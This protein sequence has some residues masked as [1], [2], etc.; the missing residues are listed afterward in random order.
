MKAKAIIENA[1]SRM[2]PEKFKLQVDEGNGTVWDVRSSDGEAGSKY[3]VDY[4]D[5][6]EE[7]EAEAKFLAKAFQQD[8]RVVP[9]S[10]P[11]NWSPYADEDCE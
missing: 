2:S 9:A 11:E 3:K 8:V 10:E 7:A 6:K 5:T 4:Y 1:T